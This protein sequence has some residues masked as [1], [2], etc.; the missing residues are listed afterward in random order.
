MLSL[1]LT[2]CLSNKAH[3]L[4]DWGHVLWVL[5]GAGNMD[6]ALFIFTVILMFYIHGAE[7]VRHTW[8]QQEWFLCWLS[9]HSS[10]LV[11]CSS[12]HNMPCQTCAG[13]GLMGKKIQLHNRRI[14]FN[15][16]NKLIDLGLILIFWFELPVWIWT[17]PS[18]GFK[19][20]LSNHCTFILSISISCTSF[21]NHT[22]PAIS[23]PHFFAVF[24]PAISFLVTPPPASSL[25]VL[26]LF[27][28]SHPFLF[29]PPLPSP[30]LSTLILNST[31]VLICLFIPLSS[32]ALVKP[33]HPSLLLYGSSP[34][35]MPSGYSPPGQLPP[36]LQSPQQLSQLTQQDDDAQQDGNQS[37]RAETR[38]GEERLALAHPDPAVVLARA[39]PE[40]Q[41]AGAAQ[42]RLPTVPHHNGQLI[43][44]L[45]QVVET[46]PPANDAGCAVYRMTKK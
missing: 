19:S 25:C 4:I 34:P 3:T 30:T 16:V 43:Q 29:H 11:L 2:G 12:S 35:S 20:P 42:G 10:M 1:Q 36:V 17:L 6:V 33:F 22:D 5:Q 31:C 44:L 41:G 39:H 46:P 9:P 38:R 28:P 15:I 8:S 23:I 13:H 37:P 18:L 32:S 7:H 40:G 24:V 26:L 14:E 21:L 45:G 27:C